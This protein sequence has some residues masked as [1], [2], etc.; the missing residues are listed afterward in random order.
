MTFTVQDAIDDARDQHFTFNDRDHPSKALLNRLNNAVAQL[1]RRIME[2][3]ETALATT[4]TQAMPLAVHENGIPLTTGTIN[5]IAVAAQPTGTPAPNPIAVEVIPHAH[6]FDIGPATFACWEVNNVL[7]LRSPASL[8]TNIASVG[9]LSVPAYTRL[10]TYAS[11]VA[12]P[13]DCRSVL[14]A[15]LAA[16]MA[17]RRKTEAL[18]GGDVAAFKAQSAAEAQA[19]YLS[20]GTKIAGRV[21]RTR[22]VMGG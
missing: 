17:G 11:A 1:R 16:F 21:Y 10:T 15:D 13:D 14:A 6:R 19:F 2:I 20:I 22:D 3:D 12:L 7:Y 18:S 4:Q 9:I 5:V 8:W